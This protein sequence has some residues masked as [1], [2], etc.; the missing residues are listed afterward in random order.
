MNETVGTPGAGD[1]GDASDVLEPAALARL[2][3]LQAPGE[4]DL[5]AELA[6]IFLADA[7]AR[8]AA[9]HGAVRSGD[10]HALR[11][12]AHTL[13]GSATTFG[14]LGVA[15]VC[16]RLE[17]MGRGGGLDEA[18]ALLPELDHQWGVA[19]VALERL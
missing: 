2:R 12:A 15:S 13:K 7:P 17:D 14:A 5:A 4:P 19:R 9:I 10:A 6:A 16:R 8:L 3:E 11:E 1:T 18:A